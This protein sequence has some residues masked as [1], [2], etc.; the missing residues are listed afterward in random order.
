M[1]IHS[2]S[3]VQLRPLRSADVSLLRGVLLHEGLDASWVASAD[4]TSQLRLQIQQ[5]QSWAVVGCAGPLD[6]AVC[7]VIGT[8]V[9]E[10]SDVEHPCVGVRG[11]IEIAY[12]THPGFRGRGLT[13]HVVD[14][15]AGQFAQDLRPDG[16]LIAHAEIDNHASRSILDNLSS[17]Q[18]VHDDCVCFSLT[19]KV[20]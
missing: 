11:D 20:A 8:A 2:V 17:H 15:A 7:I 9:T 12:W 10:V 14:Q 6:R 19:E 3:P 16:K 1:Q 5:R 13:R 4:F 18:L